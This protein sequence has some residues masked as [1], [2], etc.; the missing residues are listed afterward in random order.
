MCCALW[1]AVRWA[2]GYALREWWQSVRIWFG[3]CGSGRLCRDTLCI[4]NIFCVLFGI[5]FMI[6]MLLLI[7]ALIVV[8]LAIGIV[9]E[10]ACLFCNIVHAGCNC[11]NT[12]VFPPL[13]P[14]TP[15][16]PVTP[17][18]PSGNPPVPPTPP[19]RPPGPAPTPMGGQAT[20][21]SAAPIP[22]SLATTFSTS[23]WMLV[24]SD[25]DLD[26]LRT[27][28]RFLPVRARIWIT[29]PGLADTA[30]RQWSDRFTMAFAQCG[31]GAGRLGTTIAVA[32]A[33]WVLWR[34]AGGSSWMLHA[35]VFIALGMAG[36]LIGKLMGIARARRA[37]AAMV[38]EFLASRR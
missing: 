20:G 27:W 6:L 28:P 8:A 36:S 13:P 32:Y 3:R 21:G 33:A 4:G 16:P 23:P 5:L 26:A 25:A 18:P 14:I 9:C 19:E 11:F 22:L 35:M 15:V 38:D 34:G 12:C 10:I 17:D 1:E 30:R 29:L 31:C 2:I 37:M 7:L 24:E